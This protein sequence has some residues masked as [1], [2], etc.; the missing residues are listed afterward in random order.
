[1]ILQEGFLSLLTHVGALN[2]RRPSLVS[3]PTCISS[4]PGCG[5]LDTQHALPSQAPP[6]LARAQDGSTS[7]ERR[8]GWRRVAAGPL[9]AGPLGTE[10]KHV[11]LLTKEGRRGVAD[12]AS[13]GVLL[14]KA[15][16]AAI[17]RSRTNARP[18]KKLN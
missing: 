15:K 3:K 4:A 9:R 1:M 7:E 10:L 8:V 13:L 14:D 11:V 16:A 18:Y 6:A 2:T 12:G 5:A 17:F